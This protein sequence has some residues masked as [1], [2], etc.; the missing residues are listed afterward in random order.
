MSEEADLDHDEKQQVE[1]YENVHSSVIF[2]AIRREG[3]DELS[4]PFSALWWSGVAA[5]L[6]ISTSVLCRGFLASILPHADWAAGSAVLGLILLAMARLPGGLG[7]AA[8]AAIPAAALG[9]L[10]LMAAGELALTTSG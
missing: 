9:A 1:E 4:R 2:E 3:D 7:L 8:L 6:A 10:L 5:E